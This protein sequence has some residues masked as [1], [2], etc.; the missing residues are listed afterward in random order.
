MLDGLDLAFQRPAPGAREQDRAGAACRR[1]SG[2]D[3]ALLRYRRQQAD[4][5]GVADVHV[6]GEAAREI[7]PLDLA[8]STPSARMTIN[9]P[10]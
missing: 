8:G 5:H 2:L 6:V 7:E 9:W 1:V 4:G 3:D 10:Q